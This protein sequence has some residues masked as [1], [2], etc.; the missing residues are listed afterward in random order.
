MN[1]KTAVLDTKKLVVGAF[2]ALLLTAALLPS[3]VFAAAEYKG[4]AMVNINKAD[5]ATL[6][7]YLKGV[8]PNKADA[9]V[10]YRRANG[11]FKAIADI[12]NVPGIGEETFKDVK[13]NISTSRGKSTAPKDFKLG[14]T[15]GKSTA[16][17]KKKT[18]K[19]KTTKAKSSA[20]KK[21][22][23]TQ[24]KATST[25]KKKASTAK[26]K[27]AKTTAAKKKSTATKSTKK[28]ASTTSTK[29]RTTT[30]KKKPATKKKTTKKKSS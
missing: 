7:A 20:S 26:R 25:T 21:A 15:S 12:Q 22:S 5:A 11:N 2:F 19:A 14:D 9:I 24:K 4:T 10:K 6:A 29:K 23:T 30:K 8:G 1:I 16:S 28:K 27:T 17:K 18:T 13:K 3:T